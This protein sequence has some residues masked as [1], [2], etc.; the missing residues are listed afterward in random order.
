MAYILHLYW[1][2]NLSSKRKCVLI[3][4]LTEHKVINSLIYCADWNQW[5]PSYGRDYLLWHSIYFLFLPLFNSLYYYCSLTTGN[6]TSYLFLFTYDSF[7]LS[8]NTL[9]W[10]SISTI[11]SWLTMTPL[12]YVDSGWVV[13]CTLTHNE[14]FSYCL[15]LPLFTWL[16]VLN[17]YKYRRL[18]ALSPQTWLLVSYGT[19]V[20]S[21]IPHLSS[22]R[23]VSIHSKYS[24]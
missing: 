14:S 21:N 20:Q 7:W 17:Y 6:F 2:S 8:T 22:S 13:Y 9:L 10:L 16:I 23:L 11:V 24:S 4:M 15:Q 1:M 18:W 12:L 19:T 3:S 5:P